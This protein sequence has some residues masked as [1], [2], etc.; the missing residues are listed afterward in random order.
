MPR[1]APPNITAAIGRPEARDFLVPANWM[2]T[3]SA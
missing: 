3:W 2:A 1:L